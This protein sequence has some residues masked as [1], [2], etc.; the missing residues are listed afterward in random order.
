MA[1]LLRGTATVAGGV[2]QTELD[3]RVSAATTAA[4]GVGTGNTPT[5]AGLSAGDSNITNVGD[6]A[7][8]T[9]SSDAGTS[10]G[11]TLGSDAGDDF[12]VDSGKF[13]VEG[14]TGKIGVNCADPGAQ[15][16]IRGVAGTGSAS[17]GVLRLST[18]ETTV[19]DADQLGR[20]EFIAPLEATGTDAIVVSASIVAEADDA[21]AAANN[22]TELV[23]SVGSSDAEYG[24][25]TSGAVF[26]R[27]RIKSDGNIDTSTTCKITER[28]SCFHSATNRNLVFGY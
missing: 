10:I 23:F 4:Q 25:A 12:N 7:L 17:A 13:L 27:M 14:D 15:V 3:A 18:A 26:E 9:I 21:F 1:R 20:I 11:I 24:S 8:D 16:D 6:I 19:V 5:F 22:E 2:S 28:G